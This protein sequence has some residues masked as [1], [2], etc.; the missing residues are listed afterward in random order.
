[1]IKQLCVITLLLSFSMHAQQ[2]SNKELRGFYS[3]SQVN[4]PAI[5]TSDE[6]IVEPLSLLPIAT[7][8]PEH[9]A[10]GNK[11]FHDPQLSRDKTVSCASCHERDKGFH[12]GRATAIGINDQVGTRNTPAIFGIDQWQSFFGMVALKQLSNKHL[13]LLAIQLKWT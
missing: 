8:L 12:D 7:P 9:V 1:M 4:W 13:C 10:L 3:K 6:R 5:Q 11:L 2:Y